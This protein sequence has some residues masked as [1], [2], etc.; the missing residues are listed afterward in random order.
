MVKFDPFVMKISVVGW[1]KN[2]KNNFEFYRTKM[3]QQF[4][5]RKQFCMVEHAIIET[6]SEREAINLNRLVTSKQ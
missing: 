5:G 2:A 3:P 1:P 4:P 6:G